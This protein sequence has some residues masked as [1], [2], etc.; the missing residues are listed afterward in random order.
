[1]GGGLR[2]GRGSTGS[3]CQG[4]GEGRDGWVESLGVVESRGGGLG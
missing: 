2:G 1:M 3:G 4:A